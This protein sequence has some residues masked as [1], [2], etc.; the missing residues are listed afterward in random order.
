MLRE[1]S[2]SLFT[3]IVSGSFLKRVRTNG[4]ELENEYTLT[5]EARGELV[6]CLY[7][8][9]D[10]AVKALGESASDADKY[11]WMMDHL[12]VVR[13]SSFYQFW[14]GTSNGL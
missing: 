11:E 7:D 6:N 10:A 3:P 13:T 1:F 2:S 9:Y 14:G 8:L 12:V 4:T 5:P